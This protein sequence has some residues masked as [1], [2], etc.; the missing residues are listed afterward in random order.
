LVPILR[1]RT[2]ATATHCLVEDP[3]HPTFC[4]QLLARWL[5]AE[6]PPAAVSAETSQRVI[7]VSLVALDRFVQLLL[8]KYLQGADE[9]HESDTAHS[10]GADLAAHSG[11]TKSEAQ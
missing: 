11:D 8:D 9:S 2:T 4:Y 5:S 3:E 7:A 6:P 1:R 10:G